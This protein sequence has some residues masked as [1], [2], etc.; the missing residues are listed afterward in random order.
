MAT[1]FSAQNQVKHADHIA[2]LLI[3]K[4]DVEQGFVGALLY[5]SLAFD[6]PTRPFFVVR[7]ATGQR[8]IMLDQ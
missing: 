3:G 6:G 7:L 5:Q 1:V 4:P 8:T 2:D